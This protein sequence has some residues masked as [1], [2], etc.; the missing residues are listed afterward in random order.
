MNGVDVADQLRGNYHIKMRSR[1]WW[2]CLIWWVLET[3]I[4]NAYVAY[5]AYHH[6]RS[7]ALITHVE[8]RLKLATQLSQS[9]VLRSFNVVQESQRRRM[10]AT[11]SILSTAEYSL[12]RENHHWPCEVG[13]SDVGNPRKRVCVWHRQLSPDGSPKRTK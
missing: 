7:T 10:S 11:Q 12:P 5:K 4:C 6:R 3:A 8:F 9:G 1:K 13:Y 2:Y